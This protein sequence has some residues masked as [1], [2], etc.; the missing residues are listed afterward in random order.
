MADRVVILAD[1]RIKEERR[2][3]EPIAPDQ[4]SW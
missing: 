2:N 1:G 3:P 4:L